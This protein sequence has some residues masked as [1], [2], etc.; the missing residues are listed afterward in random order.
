[1]TQEF[2]P[3]YQA[4]S[5]KELGFDEPCLGAYY[6]GRKLDVSQYTEHGQFTIL[7]PTFSQT[8]RFFRERHGL[9]SHIFSQPNGTFVWCIRWYDDGIQKD[10]PYQDAT[11]WEEAEFACLIKLIEIVKEKK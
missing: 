3:Y 9:Y 8:F 7:A 10:I 5:L 11:T 2:V 4:L 6:P 1:M